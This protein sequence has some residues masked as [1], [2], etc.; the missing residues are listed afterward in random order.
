MSRIK[1][2]VMA[3]FAVVALSAMIASSASAAGWHVNGTELGKNSKQALTTAAAVDTAATLSI[4]TKSETIQIKC[5]GT[6]LN[7]TS[8]EIIGTNEGMAK[9]LTFT[10]CAT[11]KPATKCTLSKTTVATNPIKVF[12]TKGS[13]EADVATFDPLSEEP[14]AEI[15]FSETGNTCV[16]TEPEPINGSVRVNAPTGQ[17][18]EELQAIEGQGSFENNSLEI[19][20]DKAYIEGG[21]AL[22][23]LAS[24]SKWSFR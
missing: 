8:P 12:V 15:P 5:T 11:T 6:T 23:K 7:G 10:G 2:T 24:G 17:T 14:F 9:A 13:G 3:L 22:L 20:K 21:K 4:V 19:A 1:I 16:F 18:E